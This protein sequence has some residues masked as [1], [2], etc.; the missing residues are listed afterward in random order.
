MNGDVGRFEAN[1]RSTDKF[2]VIINFDGSSEASIKLPRLSAGRL[3]F[4]ATPFFV[5]VGS[6]GVPIPGPGWVRDSGNYRTLFDWIELTWEPDMVLGV[7][8]TQVDMFAIPFLIQLKGNDDTNKA[9]TRYGGFFTEQPQK[10]MIRQKI[11]TDIHDSKTVF[12]KLVIGDSGLPDRVISPYNGMHIGSFPENQLEDY[13]DQVWNEYTKNSLNARNVNGT[14]FMGRVNNKTNDLV[15]HAKDGETISFKKPSSFE[16]YTS[17]PLAN[18]KG[19]HADRLRACLQAS[20]LRSTLLKSADLPEYNPNLYY[21][22]P[23]VN[24][25]AKVLHSAAASGGA[26]AF[27]FDDVCDKSSFV[28]VHNPTELSIYLLG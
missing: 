28:S 11:M 25:Y 8:T 5:G 24:M 2:C 13:I 17:G 16:V 6:N 4:S 14:D 21:N 9:V 19:Q 27:G 1:T 3:Y 15:F 7:N 18:E 12:S 10:F 20:F 26:Y 22:N 23:P